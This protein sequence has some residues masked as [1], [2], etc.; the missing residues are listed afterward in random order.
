MAMRNHLDLHWLQ[1]SLISL[2]CF[3]LIAP[4]KT[5]AAGPRYPDQRQTNIE[6]GKI[7]MVYTAEGSTRVSEVM[8]L[9]IHLVYRSVIQIRHGAAT[10]HVTVQ[11]NSKIT[12]EF[13]NEPGVTETYAYH[14]DQR[15]DISGGIEVV[16]SSKLNRAYFYPDLEISRNVQ[17]KHIMVDTEDE[18]ICGVATDGR[19]P[20]QLASSQSPDQDALGI[21]ETTWNNGKMSGAVNRPLKAWCTGESVIWVPTGIDP[22]DYSMV[23]VVDGSLKVTWSFGDTP[24]KD[25]M[26]IRPDNPADYERWIPVASEL[27]GGSGQLS[28]TAGFTAK[29]NNSE[30]MKG[31][32]HFWLR[33]VSKNPGY[34]TNYPVNG[35]GR[36]SSGDDLRFAPGQDGIVIDPD[37]PRHAYTE[38]KEATEAAIIVESRDSGGFGSIQATCEELGMI[39]LY[40]AAGGESIPIPADTN[41]NHVADYWERQMGILSKNCP[42][43]WDE[44]PYPAGQR[45][46]GDGYT[47]YEEYRGFMTKSGFI[48]TNPTKKDVFV[49]DPD[50]L[51]KTYYEPYNP[52]KLALH[53]IDPTMMKFSGEAR[54]PEN[55]WVNLNTP[56]ERQYAKQYAIFVK[57]W[58][59]MG[60]TGGEISHA[61]DQ[62]NE[63]DQYAWTKN[64]LKSIYL[65]K[66]SP[67]TIEMAVRKIEDPNVRQKAYQLLLTSTV[68]HEFGHYLGIRHHAEDEGASSGV[69]DCA[70]R[71]NTKDEYAHP[72]LLQPQFRYCT[73]GEKYKVAQDQTF[74]EKPA[75]NC[76]GQIDVKSDP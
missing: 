45:R 31:R 38:S 1:L 13:G 32:I 48:R 2:I 72:E 15:S 29:D 40:E 28:F 50:G 42:E 17:A 62:L 9:E 33:N 66:I 55:R 68:I 18:R 36:E 75:H 52:A 54:N 60:D 20:G 65:L 34:C 76:F 30:P 5:Q 14:Q 71:Y 63:L 8:L 51:V 41:G 24:A 58:A 39:A 74:V 53:Y 67:G 56:S 7:T 27:G 11:G 6:N 22:P 57:R 70:M 49:Y 37:N 12:W 43:T 59:V 47:L 3:T 69:F 16:Y 25:D 73:K 26:Y 23:G 61:T 46:N 10:E 21:M 44:D 4:I 35:K 19:I 64:P